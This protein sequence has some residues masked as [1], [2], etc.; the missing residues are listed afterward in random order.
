[1]LPGYKTFR[2]WI[3]VKEGA[4]I[5]PQSASVPTGPNAED[6]ETDDEIANNPSL[7]M[8]QQG[9]PNPQK[10]QNIIQQAVQKKKQNPRASM[11]AALKATKMAQDRFG[12]GQ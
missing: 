5:A 4:T 12:Q 11:D 9:G 6:K 3:Q 1:M 7:L 2:E 8:P 10:T